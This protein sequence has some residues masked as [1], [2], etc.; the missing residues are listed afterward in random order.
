MCAAVDWTQLRPLPR[1]AP[2]NRQ[3]AAR[4]WLGRRDAYRDLPKMPLV[5]QAELVTPVLHA[6]GDRTH[7]DS[8]LSWAVLTEHP[9]ESDCTGGAVIPLPVE[10]AWISPDGRPLWLCTSLIPASHGLHAH[11]YWHKRYPAHRAE[12][13]DRLNAVT[14]AGRWKEYRTPVHTHHVERLYALTIGHA[15]T[16]EAL[17]SIVTHIGKKSSMGYGRVGR[18]TV[19]AGTH[20]PEDVLALRPVPVAYYEGRQPVGRLSLNRAW[21]PPYW[22]APWWDDCMVPA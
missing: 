9:V 16:I 2:W 7:M 19:T 15:E 20:T 8:I 4:N 1:V 11:E 22:Y 13:G 21:T 18:W 3:R 14:T 12:F 6:E 10:L 5:I 17:L